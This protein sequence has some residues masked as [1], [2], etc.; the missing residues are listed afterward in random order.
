MHRIGGLHTVCYTGVDRRCSVCAF[1]G[2]LADSICMQYTR[3][4]A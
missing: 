2:A 1:G 4:C 3:R